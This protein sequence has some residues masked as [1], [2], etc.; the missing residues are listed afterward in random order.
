MFLFKG[1]SREG[2]RI[3]S[4]GTENP[5]P[6]LLNFEVK[7]SSKYS[8]KLKTFAN[9]HSHVRDPYWD[10]PVVTGGLSCTSIAGA[11]SKAWC[12]VTGESVCQVHTQV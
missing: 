6:K 2:C 4:K 10:A 11:S 5:S 12:A 9:L 3:V 7:L 8:E 1:M